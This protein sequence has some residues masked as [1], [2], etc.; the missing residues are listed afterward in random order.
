MK[1]MC[2][3][4][5]CLADF[6]GKL[7][8]LVSANTPYTVDL[9]QF[10]YG[11]PLETFRTIYDLMIDAEIMLDINEYDSASYTLQ[12]WAKKHNI[13]YVTRRRG[14]HPDPH[15]EHHV[16]VQTKIWLVRHGFPVPHQVVF[17]Q[18][19]QAWCRENG[20]EVAIEDYL[21]DATLLNGARTSAGYLRCYLINRSWNVGEYP[22]RVSYLQEIE[23]LAVP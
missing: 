21:K 14:G 17:T 12:R 10:G 13:W 6:S 9:N 5:G 11:L 15:R 8:S 3:V 7:A 23:E 1:L 2:D 16:Q 4:D 20:A 22:R 18:D 19:K